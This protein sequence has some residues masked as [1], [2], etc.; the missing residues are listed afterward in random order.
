M[1]AQSDDQ[2]VVKCDQQ[3]SAVLVKIIKKH[4]VLLDKSQL[5]SSKG[6]KWKALQDAKAT[7][8]TNTGKSMDDKQILKKVANMKVQVKKQTDANET[9]N[10]TINLCSWEKDLFDALKGQENPTI[11]KMASAISAGVCSSSCASADARFGVCIFCPKFFFFF[12]YNLHS[13]EMI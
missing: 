1:A 6:K 8:A 3:V 12:Y 13:L 7:I 11:N 2:T 9:G 4:P 10:R 5:P